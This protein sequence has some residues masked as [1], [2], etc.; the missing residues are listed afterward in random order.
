VVV[1][2]DLER[3]GETLSEVEDAGV[4]PRALE[5]ARAVARQPPQEERRVL[6]AAVLRP[7]KREDLELEVVRIAPEQRDDSSELPVREAEPAMERVFRNGA[8][9]AS[10]D[11]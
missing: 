3:D 2:L 11:G 4:L 9:G 7:E 1:T 10:L 8:Q 6:V 5:H